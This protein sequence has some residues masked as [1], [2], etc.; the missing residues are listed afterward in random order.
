MGKKCKHEPD[1]GSTGI[2]AR[3]DEFCS[4]GLLCLKCGIS[5]FADLG[6][7]HFKWDDWDDESDPPAGDSS[8]PSVGSEEPPDDA[9]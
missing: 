3:D 5:A 4:V 8:P 6:P 9:A 2:A 7:E 1:W